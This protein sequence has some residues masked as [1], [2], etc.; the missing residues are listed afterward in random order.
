MSTTVNENIGGSSMAG[1]LGATVKIA[2]PN[3]G[4]FLVIGNGVSPETMVKDQ[5]GKVVLP[6]AGFKLLATLP[7]AGYLALRSN[8]NI[9]A[10]GPVTVDTSR[11]SKLVELLAKTSNTSPG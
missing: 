3:Q 6:M 8:R 9:Q 1:V 4:M 10:I 7:F 5:G 11:L 2:L